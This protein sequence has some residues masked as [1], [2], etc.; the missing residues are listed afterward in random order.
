M[1]KLIAIST[2]VILSLSL[3]KV[4]SPVIRVYEGLAHSGVTGNILNF[5]ISDNSQHALL[6]FGQ[7]ASLPALSNAEI[8][9]LVGSSA[10]LTEFADYDGIHKDLG[11]MMVGG[12]YG[13][14]GESSLGSSWRSYSESPGEWKLVAAHVEKGNYGGVSVQER[15]I[16]ITTGERIWVRKAT[17]ARGGYVKG[18]PHPP[19]LLLRPR[20]R[21]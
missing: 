12:G 8:D 21:V 4:S 10:N 2:L 20:R 7:I 17:D 9:L 13:S 6:S 11:D 15:W 14:G 5:P 18:H 3:A 19:Q 16:R 1:K